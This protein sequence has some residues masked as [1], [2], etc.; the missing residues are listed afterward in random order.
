MKSPSH[1][2]EDDALGERAVLVGDG[3]T[4]E[5]QPHLPLSLFQEGPFGENLLF[6]SDA[7]A[8]APAPSTI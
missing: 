6:K 2:L 1:A 7:I 5:E 8:T 4:L 3:Y